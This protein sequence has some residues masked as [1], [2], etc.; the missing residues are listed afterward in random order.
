[1][2]RGIFGVELA[3][4]LL[5]NKVLFPNHVFLL[6]GNHESKAM[7]SNYGFAEEV[8]FK[9]NQQVLD[10]FYEVFTALPL[11]AVINE[12]I[13]VLHG[14]LFTDIGVTIRDLKNIDRFSEPPNRGLMHDCLWSDPGK[15]PGRH[16]NTQR[17]GGLVFGP[18]VTES[19]LIRNK[20][21]LIVRSHEVRDA[22]FSNDH[23]GLMTIFSA[24]NYCDCKLLSN[25]F[26]Y[27]LIA[28]FLSN[29]KL[30]SLSYFERGFD[31]KYPPI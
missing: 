25:D 5:M 18:D 27:E 19:F 31:S 21:K 15:A 28:Y 24:P 1:V 26:F 2:D 11:A 8:L 29:G 14:G 16:F 10:S 23:E 20:L 3:L 12:S 4:Y 22:G 6:R 13:L 7:T 30:R 9:Y 17:N